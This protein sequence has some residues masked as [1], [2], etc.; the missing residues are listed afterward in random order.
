M[1]I[2]KPLKSG[3]WQFALLAVLA[4]P[5]ACHRAVDFNLPP[6]TPVPTKCTS[7]LSLSVNGALQQVPNRWTPSS[8]S[9]SLPSLLY[10]PLSL[11]FFSLLAASSWRLESE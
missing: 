6:A 3:Q 11:L 10:L 1:D 2:L 7:L 9:S 5:S 4:L 8:C